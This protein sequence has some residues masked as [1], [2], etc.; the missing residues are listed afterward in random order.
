MNEQ[1]VVKRFMKKR[2]TYFRKGQFYF[3]P[4]FNARILLPRGINVRRLG[5][6]AAG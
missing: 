3:I 4:R 6:I 2:F 5:F 1:K